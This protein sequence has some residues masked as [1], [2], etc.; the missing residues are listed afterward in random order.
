MNRKVLKTVEYNKIINMLAT[1]ASSEDGKLKC[2]KLEPITDLEAITRAQKN[3]SDALTR[4]FKKGALDVSGT[5][6]INDALARLDIG[7][8]IGV[9]ELLM[10]ASL[11]NIVKRA[12]AYNR[13]DR[14]EAPDS[15]TRYFN[16]LEPE[17]SVRD[18]INRCILSEDSIAD[19][20]SVG[21]KNV[22]RQMS[23]TNDKIRSQ[24]NTLLSTSASYLQDNVITM[25]N[26]RYCLPVKAE[27]KNT[28]KGMVHDQSSTGSTYFIEPAAIVDLNNKLRELELEEKEEIE[29][30]LATLSAM[31]FEIKD[32]LIQNYENLIELDFIFAKGQLAQQMNGVAP[33]FNDKGIINL[34]G[35]RHPLIDPSQ[36]VPIDITLGDEYNLLIVT[37]PNTGGKTVSLKTCG[38]FCLMGQAGLH[39]PAK[40]RSQLSIFD[41][42]FADIGDEQSIEQSLSTF[43]SHMVNI[44][45]TLAYIDKHPEKRYFTLF[46]ELCSGTDPAEGAALAISILDRLLKLG[47]TTMATT[48]YSELKLYAL[49]TPNVENASCEFSMETLSPTYNLL[50]GVPGKSNAFAISHKLGL[51]ND[52]I[53][54]AKEQIDE[55]SRSFEDVLIDLEQKRIQMERDQDSITRDKRQIENLRESIQQREDR[56]KESHDKILREANEEAAKI[57]RDAK[58]LADSTIRDFNKYAKSNPDIVKMERQRSE[59]GKQVSKHQEKTSNMKK[60]A[61]SNHKAPKKVV[62]GD[63]VRVV[64]MNA[65]GTVLTLPDSRGNLKVQMGIIQSKVN[66]SDLELLQE[67][68][69]ATM[70]KAGSKRKGGGGYGLGKA[71][72]ISPEINLIGLNSD[73]AIA[74]LDKYLD[75][76][77]ISHLKSVRIVHGKGSGV[78][79]QAVQQYLKKQKY[80]DEFHLGEFGEGDSGV[81]IA[82]FK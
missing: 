77:Y 80:V 30:V 5:H 32:S 11:L 60:K 46:D 54:Y 31:V 71:A 17:A 50:I 37:G 79:R 59:L 44:V 51:P 56:L 28:V 47:V 1:F 27:Y 58:E 63:L 6:N 52:I 48:H 12:I 7:G 15:I 72:T 3:T 9:H 20:A 35:A 8:S 62:V 53:D 29:K 19:D 25:R 21:L 16:A 4:I 45:R 41:E 13:S 70:A 39:I 40:D 26:G 2:E 57:L 65:K 33:V 23:A 69:T 73:E 24:M 14:D 67:Q 75:D 38:L 76:A 43:S 22:R 66:I 36:V 18:E 10:C 81:T 64:S 49:S 82:T 42:I 34:R 78:L 55:D 61:T 68:D 74:R